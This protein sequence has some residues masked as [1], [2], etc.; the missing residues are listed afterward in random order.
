MHLAAADMKERKNKITLK[1]RLR[2]LSNLYFM[3]G[4]NVLFFKS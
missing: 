4:F 2:F 1:V 3:I